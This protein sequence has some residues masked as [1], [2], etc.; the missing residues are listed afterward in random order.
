MNRNISRGLMLLIIA[1]ILFVLSA[2]S[3]PVEEEESPAPSI[4][5]T[6]I[7]EPESVPFTLG[8]TEADTLHP[9]KTTDQNN[10][11]IDSLVY[12]C[13]YTLGNDFEPEPVLAKNAITSEDQLTWT[14]SLQEGRFFSDGTPLTAE[15]VVSSLQTAMSGGAY[16]ARLS[17]VASV[18]ESNGRVVI[19]LFEPNGDLPA[20]LDVPIVLETEGEI[21]LGTGPYQFQSDGENQWL[22]A[23]SYW[24]QGNQPLYETISIYPTKSLSDRVTAFDS[25]LVTAVTTDFNAANSLGYSG[26][27]ETHDYPTTKMLYVGFN[28]STGP[29]TD[30][31]LRATLS[32]SFDRNSI[33]SSLLSGHGTAAALPVSPESTQYDQTVAD[34]LDYDLNAAAELIE[35]AGYTYDEDGF[36]TDGRSVLSLT[37]VVNRDSLTKQTIAGY[38]AQEL[39]SLGIGITVR[40]LSWDDYTAALEAGEFDLYLGEVKL[41]GDFD[42]TSLVAGE[43]NYGG[44]QNEEV[45]SLLSAWKTSAGLTRSYNGEKLFSAMAEDLP[46]ATLCFKKES[47]LVRWGM[48]GNLSPSVHSPFSGVENWQTQEVGES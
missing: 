33:V 27:Y 43:L 48:V 30:S 24:W 47:L 46:F 37:L 7:P 35:E 28:V 32:R 45:F 20:L 25:G 29:C 10:I 39:R 23:N 2:C 1:A 13:L 34:Q 19:T 8:W 5:V 3:V 6:E 42:F 21:P 40:E 38:L 18:S 12:E 15:Q 41:T 44:Y 9:L 16:A 36:L 14:I 22:S 11:D 26:T 4:Q 31:L 17:G